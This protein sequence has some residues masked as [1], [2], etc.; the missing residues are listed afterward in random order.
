MPTMSFSVAVSADDG[1]VSDSGTTYPRTSGSVVNTTSGAT[2]VARSFVSPNYLVRVSMMRWDTATL[3]VGATITAATLRIYLTLLANTDGRSLVAEWYA[4]SNWPIDLSDFTGT[5][6]TTPAASLSLSSVTASALN[7]LVFTDLSGI[8]PTGYTGVRFHIS[9]ADPTGANTTSVALWDSVLDPA[10]ELL[11][12]YT[13]PPLVNLSATTQGTAVV[14]GTIAH[15][16]HL[17]GALTDAVNVIATL[18]TDKNVFGGWTGSGTVQ[19][20]L[21]VIHRLLGAAMMGNGTATASIKIGHL[22]SG[23]TTGMV[24]ATTSL[25][26]IHRLSGQITGAAIATGSLNP[27]QTML[28]GVAIS[29]ADPTGSLH[30]SHSLD[31]ATDGT[32]AV[33]APLRVTPIHISGLV[34]ATGSTEAR[35]LGTFSVTGSNDDG[36]VVNLLGGG[37]PITDLLGNLTV[38]RDPDRAAVTLIRFDTSAIP[39]SAII[40]GAYLRLWITNM[41]SASVISPAWSVTGEYYSASNWPIGGDD[42][43]AA[44]PASPLFSVAK[45]AIANTWEWPGFYDFPLSN[46]SGISLTEYSGFRLHLQ[47]TEIPTVTFAAEFAS[48]ETATS[49]MLVVNFTTLKPLSG[50]AVG[51]AT[52]AGALEE[53]AY[54]LMGSATGLSLLAA[55]LQTTVHLTG[56]AT[57]LAVVQATLTVAS[58]EPLLIAGA[59]LGEGFA[60]V[61]VTHIVHVAAVVTTATTAVA[62]PHIFKHLGGSPT[63]QAVVTANLRISHVRLLGV[64]TGQAVVTSSLSIAHR[65]QGFTIGTAT[66]AATMGPINHITGIVTGTAVT[67]VVLRHIVRVRG[68]VVGQAYTAAVLMWVNIQTIHCEPLTGVHAAPGC[69]G[70]SPVSAISSENLV[71]LHTIGR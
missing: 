49:P 11:I 54:L 21:K 52:V 70:P 2:A 44:A 23:A 33:T 38:Q 67:I 41:I 55:L 58:H 51:T 24:I 50:M 13:G 25:M 17:S 48:G 26:V 19:A 22:I 29:G 18:Y 57:D 39:D 66:A 34:T 64:I 12:T 62:T 45:E 8:N 53:S 6:P 42:W 56:E 40:T 27:N 69:T 16:V 1:S 37:T 63:G 65:M 31:G 14:T 46:F 4:S 47:S 60:S 7:D 30:I 71:T 61:V 59:V 20:T 3:P 35:L 36:F 5:A 9:G 28:S 10:P 43:T 32:A 15:T 68:S